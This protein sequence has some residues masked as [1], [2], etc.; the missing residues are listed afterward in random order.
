MYRRITHV[1]SD[2]IIRNN[3]QS[4]FNFAKFLSIDIDDKVTFR[5]FID[6]IL[7]NSES[8]ENHE[9]IKILRPSFSNENLVYVL[10]ENVE[11]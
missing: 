9:E 6:N 2:I 7:K 1:K 3:I 11:L 4:R 10:G 5:P 8:P